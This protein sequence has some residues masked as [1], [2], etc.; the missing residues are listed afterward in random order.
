MGTKRFRNAPS[1]VVPVVVQVRV[2]TIVFI[3]V[4]LAFAF[5]STTSRRLAK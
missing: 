2:D 1:R 4:N 5:E 3:T